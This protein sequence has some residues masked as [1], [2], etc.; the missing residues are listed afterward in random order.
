MVFLKSHRKVAK[1]IMAQYHEHLTYQLYQSYHKCVHSTPEVQT[2]M[3]FGAVSRTHAA[4][5]TELLTG[6]MKA[7]VE[8]ILADMSRFGDCWLL[9]A[10]LGYA[11]PAI[12]LLDFSAI[13]YVYT[14]VFDPERKPRLN[15]RSIPYTEA[16][17]RSAGGMRYTDSRALSCTVDLREEQMIHHLCRSLL[18]HASQHVL[19]AQL[20]A[21]E[22]ERI[23]LKSQITGL[24]DRIFGL[25]RELAAAQKALRNNE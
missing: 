16:F 7:M 13:L 25:E 9:R 8:S 22:R 12:H 23:A 24:K 20:D 2:Y 17:S 5:Q 1:R 19:Q 15:T 11:L 14:S 4:S 3:H 21:F 18:L 6:Y 10:I